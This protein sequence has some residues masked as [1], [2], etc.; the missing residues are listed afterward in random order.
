MGKTLQQHCAENEPDIVA[1]AKIIAPISWGYEGEGLS[2]M[3]ENSLKMARALREQF[4]IHTGA[5]DQMLME[6]GAMDARRRAEE[7]RAQREADAGYLARALWRALVYDPLRRKA[8]GI[9]I[10]HR[11][12]RQA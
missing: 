7:E 8:S 11:A 6:L 4:Q 9:R 2:Y 10:W 3:R 5:A 12:A 1:A